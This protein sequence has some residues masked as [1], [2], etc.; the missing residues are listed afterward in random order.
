MKEATSGILYVR[1]RLK[2]FVGEI[3]EAG[4]IIEFLKQFFTFAELF[5]PH[6]VGSRAFWHSGSKLRRAIKSGALGKMMANY[7]GAGI[8]HHPSHSFVGVGQRVL[9]VL[10]MHDHNTSCFFPISELAKRYDFSMLLLACLDESPGFSTVHAVQYELGLSQ[11]HLVRHL[12]RW[13]VEI[14]GRV[15]SIKA[16]ESP[17]C[18]LSFDKFYPAY[19]SDGNLLRGEVCGEPYL[20]VA[21][22]RKA[23]ESERDILKGNPRFVDCGRLLCHT[24]RLRL[25]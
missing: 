15:R 19:E 13:D 21:S 2:P 11:R 7:Q 16:R 9:D 8:S 23:M 17:G 6:F 20:F 18:S 5:A 25:Y 12:L 10:E 1:A 24:C 14:G 22:A 4:G 3:K